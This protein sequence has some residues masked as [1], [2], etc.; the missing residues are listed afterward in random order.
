MAK[1]AL[2]GWP[3]SS[4]LQA[5]VSRTL[6]AAARENELK[7]A[8]VRV[9]ALALTAALDAYAHRHP[10]EA[11]GVADFPIENA[12]LALAWLAVSTA[13]AVA[14]RAGW[15]REA[16]RLVIPAMDG[17]MVASLFMTLA[18]GLRDAPREAVLGGLVNVAA[19]CALLAASGALRLTPVA[20]ALTAGL[21]VLTFAGAGALAGLHATEIAFPCSILLGTGLMGWWM[22]AMVRRAAESEVA[23]LVLER[24]L[25]GRVVRDAHE[26]PLALLATPRTLE[27]TVL[28]SDLRDFTT[29]AEGRSP[30]EVL[31]FL[32]RLQGT[33]AEIVRRHGGTVDKFMGDGMLAVFGAP[34]PLE[35]DA[36]RAI[37]AAR[38]MVPAIE[39]LAAGPAAGVRI[40]IGVHSGPIVAGCLGEGLRLEFTIIGDTV[41][42]ASRLEAETKKAGVPVLVS[43][44]TVRRAGSRAGPMRLVGRMT[45]RGRAAE[46]ETFTPEGG[47]A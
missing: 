7:V 34:D 23:R 8:Y 47:I 32:N 43:A 24:F 31:A 40:G 44:E 9:L 4:E 15:Y 2:M 45:L 46:V 17:I 33:L 6:L 14:L 36:A 16:M 37:E 1:D 39:A 12:M 29:F 13:I 27:A 38:A 25:P 11:M 41:N 10:R 21:A 5:S 26:D 20:A 3:G 30:I 42:A 19:V 35:G 18:H 22:A 28:V